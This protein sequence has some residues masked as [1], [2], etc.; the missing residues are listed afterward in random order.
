MSGSYILSNYHIDKL[1]WNVYG[2]PDLGK[3]CTILFR[4]LLLWFDRIGY[5]VRFNFHY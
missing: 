2:A 4:H 1:H 5:F 3:R